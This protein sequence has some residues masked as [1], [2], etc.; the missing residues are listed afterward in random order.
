MFFRMCAPSKEEY[1]IDNKIAGYLQKKYKCDIRKNMHK[2]KYSDED[3]KKL[4][5]IYKEVIHDWFRKKYQ[6]FSNFLEE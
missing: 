5:D 3:G 2:I 1:K 4:D 6:P